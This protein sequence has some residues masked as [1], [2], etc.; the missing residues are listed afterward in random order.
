MQGLLIW[1]QTGARKPR[2]HIARRVRCAA[3]IASGLY[4][5]HKPVGPTSFSLVQAF[6]QEQ[7]ATPGKRLSICHGGT[8]DPFAE[9]LLLMLVGQTTRLFDHLHAVPKVYEARIAWGVETDN[10]DPTG[11]AIAEADASGLTPQSIEARA[12]A[13][14]GW[15]EQVPPSTSA[16]KIDGEPAYRKVHRGE[17]VHLPPSRVYLHRLRWLEHSLPT[18][19][20]VELVC[21]GGYYVRAFARDLGRA[22]G[23]PA[24]L[25]ALRRTAIGPW[26]DPAPGERHLV[27]GRDLLPWLPSR[28]LS[29][30]ELGALRRGA[31][32]EAS[33]IDPPTWRPDQG[34]PVE[35]SPVRGYHR[36][37]L[38]LLLN[39]TSA[40]LISLSELRGGV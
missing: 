12:E 2:A 32:I 20:R 11:R 40:G 8:L 34:F 26:A 13:F 4:R 17:A 9:G 19:S 39:P 31:T 14:L 24:H 29:D 21:R 23:V 27:T 3:V 18:S 37:R 25:T 15:Q 7:A 16:K 28:T 22:L 33:R 30:A 6:Q 35:Q 1:A 5:V 10:G 38:T 36:E